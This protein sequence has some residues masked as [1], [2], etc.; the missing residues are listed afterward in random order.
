MRQRVYSTE[1][2]WR[3]HDPV[4][5]NPDQVGLLC[6]VLSSVLGVDGVLPHQSFIESG[7]TSIT[8]VQVAY[9]LRHAGWLLDPHVLTQP[10]GCAR[11]AA[12][13]LRRLKRPP[14][15]SEDEPP[16]LAPNRRATEPSAPDRRV[17]APSASGAQ[18]GRHTVASMLPRETELSLPSPSPPSLPRALERDRQPSKDERERPPLPSNEERS[19]CSPARMWPPCTWQP[20]PN[21]MLP[22]CSRKRMP[23][24]SPLGASLLLPCEATEWREG[25]PLP[26]PSLP[27][28]LGLPPTQDAS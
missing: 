25:E 7:G 28:T 12:G 11:T 1:A 16:F 6:A 4:V 10:Q 18:E 5:S 8:A 14:S 2:A 15:R 26:S 19:S 23:G 22:D 24:P 17:S 3:M 20:L 13:V 9:R 21:S 27:L